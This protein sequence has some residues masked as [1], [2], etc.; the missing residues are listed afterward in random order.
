MYNLH[1][2]SNTEWIKEQLKV[3]YFDNSLSNY[4]AWRL[5]QILKE[6]DIS[7]SFVFEQIADTNQLEWKLTA[8]EYDVF[9]NT[10]DM[11]LTTDI[12]KLFATEN[13]LKNPSQYT[14][15]RLVSLLKQYN[16]SKSKS[17]I[18]SEINKVYSTD[19]P[20]VVL[21][22][23]YVKLNVKEDI[24][25]K[26]E[27]EKLNLYEYNRRDEIYK[28][29][30]LTENVYIDKEKVRDLRNFWNFLKNPN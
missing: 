5:K 9:I 26:L 20:I 28:K 17:K 10:I 15:A 16:E 8:G 2:N 22:R 29:L 21:W 25:K 27:I 3:L 19:M 11:W 23:Q 7:D 24:I 13:S 6:H 4:I 1:T 14:D 12:S 18:A 30:S